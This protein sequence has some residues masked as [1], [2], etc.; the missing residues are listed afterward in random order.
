MFTTIGTSTERPGHDDHR[1]RRRVV[2]VLL[3]LAALSFGVVVSLA[4]G[5]KAIPLGTVVD[6]VFAR[7]T[8]PDHAT[9][10][11]GRIPRTVLAVV[12]GTGLAVAGALIQAT[13]RNPLADPGILGVNAG[14][15]FAIIL[16]VGFLGM[17][18]LSQYLWFAFFGALVVA[19]MVFFIGT[20]GRANIDPIRLTL[21][22]VA[23]GAVLSGIGEGLA[24]LRP[25]AF[26]RMRVWTVGNVDIRSLEPTESI[27]LFVGLGLLLALGIGSRLNALALGDDQAAGLGVNAN[28]TRLVALLAITL[29]AGAT[30]A[31]AGSIAF[32]GLMIPHAARWIC[33]PDHRWIIALSA[34]MGPILMLYA[35]VL[36]RVIVPGEMPVGIV[37]ALVGAPVLVMLARRRQMARL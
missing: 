29:L 17:T 15:A 22:G 23:L 13:T 11:D 20:G 37:T 6:A 34:L 3:L 21:A 28:R 27:L 24:L 19:L 36:G 4:I 18:S 16:A 1:G 9:I 32:V 10:W 26:D 25:Q 2:A 7:S 12:A 14:A 5:A 30:T 8:L 31:V 33:G 35:D